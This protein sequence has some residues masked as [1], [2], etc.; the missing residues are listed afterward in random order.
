[1]YT[2]DALLPLSGLQ[3]LLFCERQWA[4][5]H[6]E[7]QWEENRLTAEGRLL[8]AKADTGAPE[9]RRGIRMVRALP[10]RSLWLGLVGKADV[11]EFPREGG[12]PCP[13]EYKRGQAKASDCDCVQ[14]CAQALCLEEM[15]HVPVLGGAFFYAQTRRRVPVTFDAQ[16]RAKTEA[17]ATRMH[18]LYGKRETPPPILL[19]HCRNC[20][21]RELCQPAP[22]TKR[23]SARTYFQRAI[24][25]HLDFAR[26]GKAGL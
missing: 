21:L 9:Q 3:H 7:G 13:I 16:L 11:V 6:I 26:D 5:V 18:E 20:S 23:G 14:L 10:L 12:P 19:A 22:V 4:L 2:E 8:H 25:H 17:L 24:R 15:L 1:M